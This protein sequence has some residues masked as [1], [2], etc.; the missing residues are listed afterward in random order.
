MKETKLRVHLW[1]D[2]ILKNKCKP[3]KEVTQN[4]RELLE[5]MYSLMKAEGG[6]GLAANQV[7][8]DLCLVVIQTQEGLFK[9]INPRII[10]KEG[11]IELEEGCL[12][13]PNITLSIKR[14]EKVWVSS[15]DEKGNPFDIEAE[16]VLAVVLQH[17]IDHING[18]VFIERIPF[19]RRMRLRNKLKEIKNRKKSGVQ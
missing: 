8:I 18:I 7:G 10:K 11:R 5:E 16:G 3:V 13:F 12:S 9:L 6:V 1:D 4:I 17:E 14:A 15:S 2:R 19:L